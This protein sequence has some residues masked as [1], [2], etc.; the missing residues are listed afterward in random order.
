MNLEFVPETSPVLLQECKEFDF[1]NPPFNPKE[2]A[3]S[4]HDKMIK[5]E[6]RLFKFSF[7]VSKR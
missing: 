2:F 1:D 4:L 5:S 7:V 3:Q 6:R